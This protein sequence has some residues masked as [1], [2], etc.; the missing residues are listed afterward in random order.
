MCTKDRDPVL[1]RIR[2]IQKDR[3]RLDPDPQQWE[4]LS[5]GRMGAMDNG[6]KRFDEEKDHRQEK[7]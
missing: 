7:K 2:M 5:K 4:G 6:V 1:S 3:I